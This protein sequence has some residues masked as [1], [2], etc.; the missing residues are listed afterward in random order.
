MKSLLLYTGSLTYTKGFEKFF[1]DLRKKDD[2][3]IKILKS[4]IYPENPLSSF[5]TVIFDEGISLRNNFIKKLDLSDI[6][7]ST[8]NKILNDSNIQLLW[9]RFNIKTKYWKLNPI[10]KYNLSYSLII[11]SINFLKKTTFD[12]IFFLV[13]PHNL[14]IYIFWKVCEELNVPTNYIDNSPFPWRFFVKSKENI[15][16]NKNRED[17]KYLYYISKFIE[18]KKELIPLPRN[19]RKFYLSNK[20]LQFLVDLFSRFKVDLPFNYYNLYTLIRQYQAKKS[21]NKLISN[22][23]EFL[24]KKYAVLF[25]HFQ[26]ESNTCP[27]GNIFA[28]QLIAINYLNSAIKPLGISLVIR[29][30]PMIFKLHFNSTWRP[31]SFYNAIKNID[32][33]IY[34]DDF[35][36]DTKV[37]LKNSQLVA[38]VAGTVLLEANAMGKPTVCFGNHSLK[39]LKDEYIIDEFKESN[40]LRKK[41]K[42][43]LALDE[44]YIKRSILLHLQKIYKITYGPDEFLGSKNMDIIQFKKDKIT[45]LREYF[46][47]H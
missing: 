47:L 36:Q 19:S 39:S 12:E 2:L 3:N 34:F 20:F 11:S 33:D 21:Y 7:L 9:S 40:D 45:A 25:L 24:H 4:Q 8:V 35:S 41:I 42:R 6:D 14:P 17:P 22:R 28:Q 32:N 43:A 30:H 1:I 27:G 18:E 26:P 5:E 37:L 44:E 31:R 13:Y 38:S 23:D 29:E 10:E 15:V 16:I 46:D